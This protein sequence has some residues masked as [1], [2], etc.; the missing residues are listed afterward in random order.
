LT[1]HGGLIDRV[2]IL[3]G[4]MMLTLAACGDD[5]GGEGDTLFTGLSGVIIVAIVIWFFMRS[6][7]NRT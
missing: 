1:D 5:D 7:R 6:R 3:V 2:R 4:V